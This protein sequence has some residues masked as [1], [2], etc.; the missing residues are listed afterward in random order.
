MKITDIPFG[1]INWPDIERVEY[2][3]ETGTA[4]WQTQQF[5]S[6]RVRMVEYSKNYLADHWCDKGHILLVLEGELI[7]ETPN[8]GSVDLRSGQSW[9]VA[10]DTKAHRVVT[11]G[12]AKV[13]IVD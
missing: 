4:Y 3:G 13:F 8:D 7:M 9:Q 12:G 1:T 10:D 6:L 2:P 11:E 5:G